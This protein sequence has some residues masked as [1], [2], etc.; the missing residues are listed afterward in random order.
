MMLGGAHVIMNVQG[1]PSTWS[2]TTKEDKKDEDNFLA[3]I[4]ILRSN[5]KCFIN[6]TKDFLKDDIQGIYKYP[7]TAAK[8]FELLQDY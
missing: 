6:L 1:K 3:I 5:F 7:T 4:F 2:R 8:A